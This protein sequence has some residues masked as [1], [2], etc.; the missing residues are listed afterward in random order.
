[1]II[2]DVP[3]FPN[4]ARVRM[5]LAEKNATNKVTFK[6]V[7]VMGGEHRSAEFLAKNPAAAVPVLE[8]DD[9]TCIAECTAITEFIDHEFEG[10]SLTGKGAKQRAQIS[11]MNRRAEFMVMDAV[12]GYFHHAT[13]G[14]G[15]DLE[16]YQN[17]DWGQ[18]QKERA[19]EG[20]AYFDQVLA[21][22]DFVAGDEFSCADIT[23]FAGL[24][25]AGFAKI[26]IPAKLVNLAK[27]RA[28]IAARPS[29][30]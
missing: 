24:G 2:Y 19:V 25:F 22:N 27:W 13:D 15:P 8:L 20:M 7:D 23:L 29:A 21:G 30:G 1:M 14:L 6:D 4:P 5:A 9:G 11:M 18:K 16:T 28:Q 17:T 26:D 3:G 12:G 10:I